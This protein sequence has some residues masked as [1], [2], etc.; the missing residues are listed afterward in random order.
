MTMNLVELQAR[1]FGDGVRVGN[2]LGQEAN[3]FQAT[4]GS[5]D[6]RK[7]AFATPIP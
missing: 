7:T 3:S 4:I 1:G 6:T 2:D 5:K